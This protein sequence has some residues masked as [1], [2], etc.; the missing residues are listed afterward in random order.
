MELTINNKKYTVSAEDDE[1]LLTVLR[2]HLDLTGSKYGCGEGSCGACTVLIDGKATRSCVTRVNQSIGK[3][4]T[5]IEGLEKD[6]KLHPVQSAF[7]NADVFQC[8]YCAPGM[9]M[10]AVALLQKNTSPTEEQIVQSMQGNI[11]RCGTYTRI[12]KAIQD[13]STV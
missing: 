5:T 2:D 12:I 3:K 9:V 4:I 13:L 1:S 10:S 7:L 11:C 6:G 8:A